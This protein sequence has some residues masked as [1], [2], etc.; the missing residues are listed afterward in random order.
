VR[1]GLA[2]KIPALSDASRTW[3]REGGDSAQAGGTSLLDV[4]EGMGVRAQRPR[5]E[6]GL[7]RLC[8]ELGDLGGRADGFDEQ[9]LLRVEIH[10]VGLVEF[11]ATLDEHVAGLLGF[12]ICLRDDVVDLRQHGL[13]TAVSLQVTEIDGAI[14]EQNGLE[15][16][17]KLNIAFA[18]AIGEMPR[19]ESDY[20]DARDNP[21]EVKKGET[22]G[23]TFRAPRRVCVPVL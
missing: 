3:N 2:A 17:G 19:G 5:G 10:A 20:H 12:W 6:N 15:G 7:F 8:N 22:C 13:M 4:A 14:G 9:D 18:S 16:S 23:V 1:P 21:H 11:L